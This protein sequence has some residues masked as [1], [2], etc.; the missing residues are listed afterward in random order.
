MAEKRTKEEIM[1]EAQLA[2]DIT[3][4]AGG[5]RQLALMVFYAGHDIAAHDVPKTKVATVRQWGVRG[6][7]AR[8]YLAN[9]KLF[10]ELEKK[11]RK[12]KEAKS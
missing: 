5:T 7:P 2:K 11:A 3:L 8:E 10:L 12:I 9:Q 4:A 1:R 6:I